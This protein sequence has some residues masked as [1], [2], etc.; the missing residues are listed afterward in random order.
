MDHVRAVEDPAGPGGSIRSDWLVMDHEPGLLQG[1]HGATEFLAVRVL[2]EDGVLRV[3][4]SGELD[5][6]EVETLEREVSRAVETWDS[7]AYVK[8]DLSHLRFIDVAGVRAL[9][10]VCRNLEAHAQEL[11]V[12]GVPRHVLRAVEVTD[13]DVPALQKAVQQIKGEATPADFG[14]TNRSRT[15]V[16]DGFE[17]NSTR[18]QS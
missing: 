11:R 6:G 5:L 16:P 8:L 10:S 14:R 17:R 15:D 9:A 13:I 12:V 2:V 4:L 3:V 1:W 7:P 18:S